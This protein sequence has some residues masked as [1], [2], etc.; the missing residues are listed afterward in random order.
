MENYSVYFLKIKYKS[1][2]EKIYVGHTNN[3]KRRMEEHK[4]KKTRGTRGAASIKLVYSE[5]GFK[6]R[7]KAWQREM[8][9]KK[10]GTRKR[11]QMISFL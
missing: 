6:T 10:I 4:N 11:K 1:G 3:L 2:F 8:Q 7:Q 5:K 9:L